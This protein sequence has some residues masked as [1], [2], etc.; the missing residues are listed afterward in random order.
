MRIDPE[1][2][3][4]FADALR[5]EFGEDDQ[6]VADMLEGETDFHEVV[7]RLIK[8]DAEAEAQAAACK[9]LADEYAARSRRLADRRETIKGALHG[10]MDAT[11]QRKV[12]HAYATVSVRAVPPKVIFD[13]DPAA[14]DDAF[15]KVTIT[16]DRTALKAALEAGT[17]I[18]GASLSNGGETI[19]VRRK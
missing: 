19:S 17:V 6:L 12:A 9:A 4:R 15:R 14:L 10:L 16:P 8:D 5:D 11:G 1:I 3:R 13:G 2:Y 7:G 18:P